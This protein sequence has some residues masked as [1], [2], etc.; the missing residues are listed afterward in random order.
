VQD[1]KR[2]DFIRTCW[3][4][5]G[6]PHGSDMNNRLLYRAVLYPEKEVKYNRHTKFI[7]V[8]NE[9]K[10]TLKFNFTTWVLANYR[11]KAIQQEKFQRKILIDTTFFYQCSGSVKFWYGSD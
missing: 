3:P 6:C 8:I 5:S 2:T 1:S 4:T 10:A 7:S 11:L 9:V